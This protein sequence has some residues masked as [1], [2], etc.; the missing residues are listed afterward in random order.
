MFTVADRPLTIQ[1][2]YNAFHEFSLW[3]CKGVSPRLRIF[4][5]ISTEKYTFCQEVKPTDFFFFHLDPNSDTVW[6]KPGV[7]MKH[8]IK[9]ILAKKRANSDRLTQCH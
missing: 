6:I 4:T 9:K 7:H 1:C 3:A 5:G 2:S 8:Q